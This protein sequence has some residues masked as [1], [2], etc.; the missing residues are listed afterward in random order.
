M[1]AILEVELQDVRLRL[2][3]IRKANH[4]LVRERRECASPSSSREWQ[5]SERDS[6]IAVLI[7]ALSNYDASAP[8][9][10]LRIVGRRHRWNAL[11]ATVLTR[12]IEDLF[13]QADISMIA[14]RLDEANDSVRAIAQRWAKEYA[15]ARWIADANAHGIAPSC[16][17]ILRRAR[18][19][20]DLPSCALGL[21]R[22]VPSKQAR[23]WLSRFRKRWNLRMGKVYHVTDISDQEAQEKARAHVCVLCL[24]HPASLWRRGFWMKFCWALAFACRYRNDVNN[25]AASV[26][27]RCCF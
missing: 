10:F 13:L 22:G 9:V 23:S 12:K 20:C 7:Y 16:S 25:V 1:T 3:E 15:L 27:L 18:A 8:I 4:E 17:T 19:L 2:A 26:E 6:M 21:R 5:L 11:P 24:L 14:A